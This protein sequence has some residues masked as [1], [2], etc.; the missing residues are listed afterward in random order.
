MFEESPLTRYGW[1]KCVQI[2][3]TYLS[4]IRW[5]LV[6][7]PLYMIYLCHHYLCIII[8]CWYQILLLLFHCCTL[9]SYTRTIG[10]MVYMILLC[11]PL[12]IRCK[13]VIKRHNWYCFITLVSIVVTWCYAFTLV[14][15]FVTSCY[16]FTLVLFFVTWCYA[17]TLVLF[18]VTWCYAFTLVPFFVTWC[19]AFTLV[20]F[21][22]TCC[23]LSNLVLDLH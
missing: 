14:P 15:F 16:A 9:I 18:F 19:Y 8:T 10:E 5:F 2:N 17:F 20:L 22:V 6:I 4:T 1:Y 13:P 23:L 21:F 12:F 3:N 11:N 7:E